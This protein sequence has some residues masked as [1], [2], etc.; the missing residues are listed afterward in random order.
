MVDPCLEHVWPHTIAS[1]SIVVCR[2]VGQIAMLC[3]YFP[4]GFI[5]K[6]LQHN[7]VLVRLFLLV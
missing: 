5:N 1:E 3:G 2:G 7:A 6:S 4:E